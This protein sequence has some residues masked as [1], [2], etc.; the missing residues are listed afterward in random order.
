[1]NYSD[2]LTAVITILEISDAY[3]TAAFTAVAPRAIEY[4]ELRMLRQFD[5]LF[6]R[7]VDLTQMTRGGIRAVPIP[8]DFVV[9]EGVSLIMPTATK[10]T[11]QNSSRVSLLRTS[12]QFMDLTWPVETN[13][14]SPTPFETYWALFSQQESIDDS[15]TADEPTKMPSAILI[16]PT[17]DDEYVVEFTGTARPA[18]LT[19]TN[20]DTY[21]TTYMPD[22]FLAATL[23]WAFGY[24]RDFG[25][26]S[27]NPQA[28][29][30]WEQTYQTLARDLDIETLRQKAMIG[31]FSPFLPSATNPLTSVVPAPAAPPGPPVG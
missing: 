26:A 10:P 13:V 3:G 17:P 23:I 6:T 7:T 8:A 16:A 24:Q 14:A 5:F 31:G 20:P 19:S 18:P 11:A 22:L 21:L 1:M 2:W 25:S 12:R 29:Q 4:A 15:G 28:A 27:N 30:S 9:I